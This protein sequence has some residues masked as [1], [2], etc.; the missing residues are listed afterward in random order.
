MKNNGIAQGGIVDT[1]DGKWYC[2]IFQDTGSVGRIPMLSP[3]EWGTE[4]ELKDWPVIGTYLGEG[5][6]FLYN[7]MPVIS[8]LPVRTK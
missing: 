1:E 3:M 8:E 2:F 5:T 6:P 4:G 7:K